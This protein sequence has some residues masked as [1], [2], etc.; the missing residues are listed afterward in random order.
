MHSRCTIDRIYNRHLLTTKS[1]WR[2][3]NPN[4]YRLIV[5]INP[6]PK[7]V[8]TRRY[9]TIILTHRIRSIIKPRPHEPRIT[10]ITSKPS[11]PEIRSCRG[12]ETET[13]RRLWIEY[14]TT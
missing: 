5:T 7:N 3:R 10:K 14:G 11:Q 2:K 6:N 1:L 4:R 9:P 12:H 13:Y 8:R